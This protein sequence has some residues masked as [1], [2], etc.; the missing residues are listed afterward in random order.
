M[1]YGLGMHRSGVLFCLVLVAPLVVGCAASDD[2][3]MRHT[4]DH[5]FSSIGRAV[6]AARAAYDTYLATADQVS[7]DGGAG[8]ESLRPLVTD[9]Q[10]VLEQA[11]ADLLR[12]G[13]YSTHGSSTYDGVKLMQQFDYGLGVASVTIRVCLDTSQLR[14]ID[15]RGYDITAGPPRRAYDVTFVTSDVPPFTLLLEGADPSE[16][17]TC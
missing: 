4:H 10:F 7:A 5:T 14:T 17:S 6:A 2:R 8:V 11:H 1:F 13:G 9:E 16:P 3:M 15:A 12:L